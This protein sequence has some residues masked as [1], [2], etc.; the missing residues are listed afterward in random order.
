MYSLRSQIATLENPLK[1]RIIDFKI[2][3][4]SNGLKQSFCNHVTKDKAI[5]FLIFSIASENTSAITG[6]VT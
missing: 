3:W 4:E 1:V 5:H 6:L 2:M